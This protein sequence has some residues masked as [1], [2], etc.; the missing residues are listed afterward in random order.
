MRFAPPFLVFGEVDWILHAVVLDTSAFSAT[1]IQL[2][3]LHLPLYVPRQGVSGAYGEELRHPRSGD[4]WWDAELPDEEAF[5]QAVK[6]AVKRQAVSFLTRISGPADL[7]EY[8]E[9]RY[10]NST[11]PPH[12]EVEALSWAL[13]GSTP[14][15]IEACERMERAVAAMSPTQPWGKPILERVRTVQ[16]LAGQGPNAVRQIMG[17]WRDESVRQHKLEK[18]TT[19]Y[20]ADQW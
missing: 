8:S 16:R 14:K 13:A 11:N 19:P 2:T 15:V 1:S 17:R 4:L 9:R 10:P 12:I 5:A 7:A 18:L 3:A 20:T 6:D